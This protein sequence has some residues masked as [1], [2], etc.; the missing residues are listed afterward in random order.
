MTEGK[1]E[2]FLSYKEPEYRDNLLWMR[3]YLN[4]E[5]YEVLFYGVNGWT[6]LCTCCINNISNPD[7]PMDKP[8]VPDGP[9][10]PDDSLCN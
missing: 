9:Y 1:V 2:L 8:E 10:T 3:P 4:K 7:I 6:P 5:G